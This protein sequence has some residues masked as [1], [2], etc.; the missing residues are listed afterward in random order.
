MYPNS[1]ITVENYVGYGLTRYEKNLSDENSARIKIKSR[2][3]KIFLIQLEN[4][5]K[6]NSKAAAKILLP[7]RKYQ[8]GAKCVVVGPGYIS[9]SI[10]VMSQNES[11]LIRIKYFPLINLKLLLALCSHLKSARKVIHLLDKRT[12]YYF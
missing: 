4:K 8:D 12:L 7:K 1:K 9:V 3:G 10:F 2:Q 6:T 5:I 11:K